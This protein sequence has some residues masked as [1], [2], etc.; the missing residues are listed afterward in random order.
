MASNKQQTAIDWLMEQITYD[1]S[2][3]RWASFRGTVDLKIFFEQ[4]KEIEKE[5]IIDAHYDGKCNGMDISHPLSFTKEIFGE[6][7]YN[8]TFNQ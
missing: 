2:G 7:Y 5:Q 3:E 1:S 4:A 6:E 8:E